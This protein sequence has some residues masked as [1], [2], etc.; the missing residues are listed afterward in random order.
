MKKLTRQICSIFTVSMPAH[1][2]ANAPL[3]RKL[4]TPR[5]KELLLAACAA[6]DVVRAR[7]PSLAALQDWFRHA[8]GHDD[9]GDY[10]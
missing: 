2:A 5:H 3:L 6:F 1:K 8:I 7:S 9:G 4:A 10:C